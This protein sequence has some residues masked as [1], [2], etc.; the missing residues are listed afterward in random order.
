MHILLEEY[1]YE[2]DLEFR[3]LNDPP[4]EMVKKWELYEKAKKKGDMINHNT[5]TFQTEET[6]KNEI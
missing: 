5:E 3:W 1:R 4:P 2:I 6:D